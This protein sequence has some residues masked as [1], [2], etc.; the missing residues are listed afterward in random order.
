MVAHGDEPAHLVDDAR[1]AEAK[2]RQPFIARYFLFEFIA[3]QPAIHARSLDREI[4]LVVAQA[5]PHSAPTL[6][7]DVALNDATVRRGLLFVVSFN[8]KL[9]LY[10]YRHRVIN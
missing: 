10:L 7:A 4:G 9:T 8:K 3:R 1:L 5:H 2:K 6:T